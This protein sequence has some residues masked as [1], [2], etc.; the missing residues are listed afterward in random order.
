MALQL[1]VSSWACSVVW[2]L[3]HPQ[4]EDGDIPVHSAA[5]GQ[6]ELEAELE[7]IQQQ[8]QRYQSTKYNLW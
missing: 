1:Q 2:W 7:G 8:L 6:A 5:P 3:L 4:G